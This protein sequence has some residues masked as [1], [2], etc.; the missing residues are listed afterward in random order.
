M[1]DIFNVATEQMKKPVWK[2]QHMTSYRIQI[3]PATSWL[4]FLSV[5]CIVSV[6]HVISQ[7]RFLRYWILD[8]DTAEI[9]SNL[10]W[11]HLGKGISFQIMWLFSWYLVPVCASQRKVWLIWVYSLKAGNCKEWKWIYNFQVVE[12]WFFRVKPVTAIIGFTL[13]F[14]Q[15]SY[16]VSGCHVVLSS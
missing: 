15:I 8:L 3:K 16:S 11:T 6:L 4:G 2:V 1:E 5:G 13:A 12:Y 9:Y 7:I 14:L 10:C